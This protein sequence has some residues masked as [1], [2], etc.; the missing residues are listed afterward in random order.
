MPGPGAYEPL[1]TL[2][3]ERVKSPNLRSGSKRNTDLYRS[4]DIPG[5]G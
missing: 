3:K 1:D 2:S 4:V 5:P